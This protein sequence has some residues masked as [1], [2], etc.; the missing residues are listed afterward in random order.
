MFEFNI[1]KIR[2]KAQSLYGIDGLLG[3]I[4]QEMF[5]HAHIDKHDIDLH[6]DRY[7]LSD[8][9]IRSIDTKYKTVFMVIAD[10]PVTLSMKSLLCPDI[11]KK[12]K[13][14]NENFLAIYH[15]M[16]ESKR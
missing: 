6:K 5:K 1:F 15:Q 12:L 16:E 4:D 11:R 10:V 9:R 14:T 3:F 13:I 2:K 7:Q 8:E